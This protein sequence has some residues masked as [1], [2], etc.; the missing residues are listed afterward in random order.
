MSPDTTT[1]QDNGITGK[2]ITGGIVLTHLDKIHC[3]QEIMVLWY[4]LSHWVESMPIIY[5]K[6]IKKSAC[7]H[8]SIKF[9]W[10]LQATTPLFGYI[11]CLD[12]GRLCPDSVHH[13]TRITRYSLP[14]QISL[15]NF[16]Q[17]GQFFI[18]SSG[19]ILY[20]WDL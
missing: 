10:R 2:M 1:P 6:K 16:R 17:N 12:I 14:S 20:F 13:G 19:Q 15:N 5:I 8:F 11:F 7:Q 4:A 9:S 3:G 18:L